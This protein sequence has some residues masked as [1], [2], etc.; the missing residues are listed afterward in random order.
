MSRCVGRFS[1]A[2][3]DLDLDLGQRPASQPA[4]AEIPAAPRPTWSAP[5][6]LACLGAATL[7]GVWMGLRP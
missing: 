2:I 7:L 3:V 5:L 4:R 1:G 6:L